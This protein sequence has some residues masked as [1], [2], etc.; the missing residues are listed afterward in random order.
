[1]SIFEVPQL[2]ELLQQLSL[3]EAR[4]CKEGSGTGAA[5]GTTQEV[6]EFSQGAIAACIV[7]PWLWEVTLAPGKLEFPAVFILNPLDALLQGWKGSWVAE[8]RNSFPSNCSFSW[9]KQTPGV[10]FP[11]LGQFKITPRDLLLCL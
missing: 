1:M 7:P 11:T 9:S 10:C 2:L 5:L 4:E 6:T 8:E 3:E